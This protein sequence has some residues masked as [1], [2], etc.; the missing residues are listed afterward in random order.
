MIRQ[1]RLELNGGAGWRRG[2]RAAWGHVSIRAPRRRAA[3]V[4]LAALWVMVLSEP[5]GALTRIRDIARPL[6]ERTNKLISH[7]MVVG[8]NGTGDGGDSL[9]ATRPMREMLEKLGNPVEPEDL[10][11]AKNFA[12]VVVTAELGRNGVLDGDQIDVHVESVYGAKSLRGGTLLLTPMGGS[13]YED[14]RL[15]AIAQGPVSIPDAENPTSGIVKNGANIETD[16]V[17]LFVDDEK[18]TGRSIFTLV[19]DDDQANWQLAKTIA[20]SI[21]EELAPPS[22]SGYVDDQG[23]AWV[24]PA[25]VVTPKF[26]EV[27]IPAQQAA[28]AA[29]FI[30]RIMNLTINVPDPEAAVVINEKAGVI[31]LTGNV[32]IAPVIV[33]VNGLS[34]RVVDPAPEANPAQP[35]IKQS[36]WGRFDTAQRSGVKLKQLMDA[37][38]QLNV[39]IEDKINTLHEIHRVGALRATIRTE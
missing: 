1:S 5:L 20:D 19:I 32:E 28:Y 30:A 21:N 23:R 39:S 36:E 18:Y 7:G 31:V 16:I 2:L 14:D 34:I 12:Y 27:T 35:Q 13:H 33:H 38:D 37:L 15:Y 4:L 8:L 17:Y 25:T 26:V 24:P 22:M 29:P 6:G 10:K 9:V 11:D 3:L